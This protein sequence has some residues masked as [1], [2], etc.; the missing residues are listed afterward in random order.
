MLDLGL[1]SPANYGHDLLT[2]KSSRSEPI[3]LSSSLMRSVNI[4]WRHHYTW[5]L[6]MLHFLGMSHTWNVK[7]FVKQNPNAAN[8]CSVPMPI[9]TCNRKINISQEA[10]EEPPPSIKWSRVNT[11]A[12]KKN[13]EHYGNVQCLFKV[14]Q[15]SHTAMRGIYQQQWK[16]SMLDN[17]CRSSGYWQFMTMWCHHQQSST[18]D[19]KVTTYLKKSK[20]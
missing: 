16:N 14:H 15:E 2:C 1:Q 20:N 19:S 9:E 17:V 11:T 5:L 4:I 8:S 12:V 6:R 18:I 10:A 7:L 3:T 13:T